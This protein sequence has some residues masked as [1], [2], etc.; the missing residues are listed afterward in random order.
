MFIPSFQI[1][2]SVLSFIPRWSGLFAVLSFIPRWSGL[3]PLLSFIFW[4]SSLSEDTQFYFQWVRFISRFSCLF[5]GTWVYSPALRFILQHLYLF[6]RH[7]FIPLILK[8]IPQCSDSFPKTYIYL[9][10]PQVYSVVL[11][12]IQVY[13]L[14]LKSIRWCSILFSGAQIYCLVLKLFC[15]AQVYSLALKFIPWCSS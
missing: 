9:H 1:Y 3:F 7:Q 12:S 11:K 5:P 6:T 2:Y 15:S 13:S 10:Y 14:V 8:S 4:L